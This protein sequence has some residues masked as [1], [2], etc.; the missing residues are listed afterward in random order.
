MSEMPE[1]DLIKSEAEKH[2]ALMRC[3]D[4]VR[5]I[6]SSMEAN[7]GNKGPKQ[8]LDAINEYL[9]ANKIPRDSDVAEMLKKTGEL[10]TWK[11]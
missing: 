7:I 4:E 6:F 5:K 9:D 11:D 10:L 1:S 2:E 8:M 3:F